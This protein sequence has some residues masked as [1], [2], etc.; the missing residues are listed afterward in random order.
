MSNQY[1]KNP[2]SLEDR[3]WSKV[4]KS[5]ECWIWIACLDSKN[6][7]SFS[8][9]PGESKLAHRA[10][11]ELTNGPVPAGL[12]VCHHC[13]NPPCVR[14]DHLF[15]GTQSDNMEDARAKGRQGRALGE[16]NAN[17]KLTTTKAQEIRRLSQRGFSQ[18]QLGRLFGVDHTT[19]GHVLR[20]NT[21]R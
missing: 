6:Y 9:S 7:G 12:F 21:W 1:T 4:D 5:G 17:A 16:R 2:R 19:I 20:C 18:L 3:F 10:A 15:L 11:W 8:R 14:L 13:D